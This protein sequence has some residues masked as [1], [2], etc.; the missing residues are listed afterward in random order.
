[1]ADKAQ[2]LYC[3]LGC[4]SQHK[5]EESLKLN[6]IMN[7]PVT[8]DDYKRALLIYRPDLA[9]IKGKTTKGSPAPHT[10]SFLAIP[11]PAPILEHHKDVTL[12]VDFFFVQVQAFLPII[13]RNIQHKIVDLVIDQSKATMIKHVDSAIQLFQSRGFTITDIDGDIEFG[14]I[15]DHIF[16]INLNIFAADSHVGEVERYIQTIKERNCS[17]V[18]GLPFK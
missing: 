10:P 4:Q 3:K 18:R 6:L 9:T 13:S 2:E 1:L 15:Q 12:C 11:I 8:I 17:T 14:C 7:Y 5:F 16:P